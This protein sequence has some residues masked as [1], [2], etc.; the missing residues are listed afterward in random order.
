MMLSRRS[1][2]ILLF[3]LTSGLPGNWGGVLLS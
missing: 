3:M 2:A 1:L